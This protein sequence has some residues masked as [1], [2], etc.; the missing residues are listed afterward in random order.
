VHR[1]IPEVFTRDR[2]VA[3]N[4]IN[5]NA[6]ALLCTDIDA[7][8]QKLT[9]VFVTSPCSQRPGR[10]PPRRTTSDRALLDDHRRRKKHC[11]RACGA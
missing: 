5:H 6:L 7:L 2:A 10:N 3:F 1:T 9:E 4:A 8:C 11:C